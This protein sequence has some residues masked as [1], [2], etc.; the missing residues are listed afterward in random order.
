MV[1]VYRWKYT[2]MDIKNGIVTAVTTDNA[3]AA[4]E[5]TLITLEVTAGQDGF[6]Y[7]ITIECISGGITYSLT[8]VLPSTSEYYTIATDSIIAT[9]GYVT[10]LNFSDSTIELEAEE[11]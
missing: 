2:K 11:T 5:G 4:D 7:Q 1:I 10:P 3:L 9:G 8:K 6:L